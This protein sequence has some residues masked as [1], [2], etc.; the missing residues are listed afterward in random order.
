MTEKFFVWIYNGIG[1]LFA[2]IDAHP[3]IIDRGCAVV[4][5]SNEILCHGSSFYNKWNITI[6]KLQLRTF[7]LREIFIYNFHRVLFGG[8]LDRFLTGGFL[9]HRISEILNGIRDPNRLR[10]TIH[11]IVFAILK[12]HARSMVYDLNI[13]HIRQTRQ[14]FEILHFLLS[15]DLLKQKCFFI[16]RFDAYF[17]VWSLTTVVHS[18]TLNSSII[19]LT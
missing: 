17:I 7:H 10:Y 13:G 9:G 16:C 14:I 18:N 8:L 15:F 2:I 11:R 6:A 19:A 4:L 1:I 3:I 5:H 12:F